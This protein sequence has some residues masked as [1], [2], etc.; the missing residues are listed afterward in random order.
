M[1][2]YHLTKHLFQH[3]SSTSTVISLPPFNSRCNIVHFQNDVVSKTYISVDCDIWFKRLGNML[4]S[5]MYM[6]L[7]LS[8]DISLEYCSICPQ[9]KQTRL[10][11][12][13][14]NVV[15]RFDSYIWTFGAHSI[16][17]HIMG[18]GIS[19]Q[20]LMI[21]HWKLEFFLCT[22]SL[23]CFGSL[24]KFLLWLKP[25]FLFKLSPLELTTLLIF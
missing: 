2:L 11:F 14:V 23:I 18:R 4:I 20:Y 12:P 7:F 21:F 25:S 6:L 10:A 8:K 9:S 17:I 1:G 3:S 15:F 19:W 13:K 22:L 5:R 24:S 16:L